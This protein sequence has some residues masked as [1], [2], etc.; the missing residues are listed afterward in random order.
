[1]R[2]HRVQR[3]VRMGV[4]GEHRRVRV[5]TGGG[6]DPGCIRS[7]WVGRLLHSRVLGLIAIR[8][9]RCSSIRC[10]R[11]LLGAIGR[12]QQPVDGEAVLV[13]L[14]LVVVAGGGGGGQLQ[15]Q[16]RRH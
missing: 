2:E 12:H 1:M 16:R 13:L 8:L 7:S 10:T 14:L 6:G 9:R 3:V 11:L 5:T 15:L 4:V